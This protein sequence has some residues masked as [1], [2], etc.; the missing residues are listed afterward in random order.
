MPEIEQQ[1][2]VKQKMGH[3]LRNRDDMD[4]GMKGRGHHLCQELDL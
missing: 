3:L 4:E 1:A 2:A